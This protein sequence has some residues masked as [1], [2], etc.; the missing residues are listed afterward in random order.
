MG[1]V[2]RSASNSALV[3]LVLALA[4]C[5]ESARPLP[6]DTSANPAQERAFFEALPERD[7]TMTC[8]QI[9]A[10]RAAVD[11]AIVQHRAEMERRRANNAV[12]TYFGGLFIVPLIAIDRAND[13]VVQLNSLNERKDVLM[14]MASF[15]R[16]V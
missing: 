12:A 3:F 16:C 14:R 5:A 4:A 1:R 9:G 6:P 7:R 11:D 15:R 13:V 8:A 2:V 10:E